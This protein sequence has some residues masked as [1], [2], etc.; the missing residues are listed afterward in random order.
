MTGMT[1]LYDKIIRQESKMVCLDSIY[2]AQGGLQKTGNRH[3]GSNLAAG[4]HILQYQ[5]SFCLE[6]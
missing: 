2:A 1:G 5:L 3:D 6:W 4:M